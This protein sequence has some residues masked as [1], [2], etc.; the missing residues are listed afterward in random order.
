MYCGFTPMEVAYCRRP[1]FSARAGYVVEDFHGGRLL[2]GFFRG[3][4]LL[5][6]PGA[7]FC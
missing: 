6:K 5:G 3:C 1:L 2:A 7:F 4:L